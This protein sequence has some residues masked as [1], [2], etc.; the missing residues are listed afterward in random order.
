MSFDPSGTTGAA[1]TATAGATPAGSGAQVNGV[2][3]PCALPSWK[4]LEDAEAE[5]LTHSLIHVS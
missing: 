1:S 4:T 5:F 2:G 3:R